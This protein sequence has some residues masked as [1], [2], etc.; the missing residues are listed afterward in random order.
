[1]WLTRPTEPP[2]VPRFAPIEANLREM[3]KFFA[4][5][6]PAGIL[7]QRDGLQL[8]SS[9]INF[10]PAKRKKLRG[11]KRSRHSAICAS[12]GAST[13]SSPTRGAAALT[14]SLRLHSRL[15]LHPCTVVEC[16]T[17][18]APHRCTQAAVARRSGR[19]TTGRAQRPDGDAFGYCS[20]L[21]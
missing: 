13:R 3:M 8:V 9:G 2:P 20:D 1:M 11:A 16:P 15:H 10:S 18:A 5:A 6:H 12:A 17:N 21:L 4:L 19:H 7:E 14:S